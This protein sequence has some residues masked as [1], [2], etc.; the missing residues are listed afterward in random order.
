MA[1]KK[2]GITLILLLIGGV[3]VFAL[4]S[5]GLGRLLSTA[6][7]KAQKAYSLANNDVVA[8]IDTILGLVNDASK[9]LIAA[10][11]YKE[12]GNELSESH[13]SKIR[14]IDADLKSVKLLA[15]QA[16]YNI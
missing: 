5:D 1:K 6:Q 13:L 8:N 7:G 3:S 9:A 14:N 4:D 10:L 12:S 2:T 16:G 11:N 15:R